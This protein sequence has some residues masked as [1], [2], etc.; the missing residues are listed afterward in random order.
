MI[1]KKY[2]KEAVILALQI[3]VFVLEPLYVMKT[4]GDGFAII[5]MISIYTII[6]G[7]LMGI[8]SK[9]KIKYYYPIFV[10]VTFIPI[11]FVVLNSSAL[12]YCLIYPV[13]SFIGLVIGE[14]LQ[15]ALNK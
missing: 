2:L 1:I 9:N 4:S 10:G 7:F 13:L 15:K 3:V 6:L 5:F 14:T 12:I 8:L 11:V